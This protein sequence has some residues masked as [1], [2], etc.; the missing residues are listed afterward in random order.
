[1]DTLLEENNNITYSIHENLEGHPKAKAG[2]LPEMTF[3]TSL[4]SRPHGWRTT[5]ILDDLCLEADAINMKKIGIDTRPPNMADLK[6][7]LC[8][9]E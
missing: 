9:T 2:S 5:K 6:D 3:S 1:L 4:Q 8:P 7:D